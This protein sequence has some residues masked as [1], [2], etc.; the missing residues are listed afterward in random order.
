MKEFIGNFLYYFFGNILGVLMI[1]GVLTFIGILAT[2]LL[3][4]MY[5]K[6]V[7]Y[8]LIYLLNR[9]QVFKFLPNTWVNFRKI[10]IILYNYFE[11]DP[12]I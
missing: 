9:T 5:Y 6:N 10:L 8:L 1:I 11:L 4:S 12:K 3:L 7:L 2:P